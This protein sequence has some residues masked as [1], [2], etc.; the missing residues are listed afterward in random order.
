MNSFTKQK[1][2]Q[3]TYRINLELP[4]GKDGEEG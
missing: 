3:K 2:T 4:G 1:Q